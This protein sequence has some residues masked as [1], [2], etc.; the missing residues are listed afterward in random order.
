MISMKNWL[1]T[2]LSQ[3]KKWMLVHAFLSS[4]DQCRHNFHSILVI[5]IWSDQQSQVVSHMRRPTS[6]IQEPIVQYPEMRWEREK[7]LDTLH[8]INIPHFINFFEMHHLKL[9]I[10]ICCC[11][12]GLRERERIVVWEKQKYFSDLEIAKQQKEKKKKL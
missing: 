1:K 3:L 4:P 7:I 6:N 11:S 10:F 2:Y 12:R 5:A 8:S 9:S